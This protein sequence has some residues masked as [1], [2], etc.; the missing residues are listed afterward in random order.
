MRILGLT[1]IHGVLGSS[2][3]PGGGPPDRAALEP[4]VQSL[5]S[6]A[7]SVD[8]VLIAGDATHFGGR[9]EAAAAIDLL[10]TAGK[11]IFLVP[12]N[13]DTQGA[14]EYFDDLGV[15]LHGNIVRFGGFTLAGAGGAL[16]GPMSTPTVYS[17]EQFAALFDAL[18]ERIGPEEELI[19]VS[20]QPPRGTKLDRALGVRHVGS[21]AVRGWIERTN[22]L[23]CLCGHMHESSGIDRLGG[24]LLVNPGPFRHGNYCLI[25]IDEKKAVTATILP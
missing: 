24:T 23:L 11:P 21:E 12:G 5:L 14:I 6:A 7:E 25:E 3:S 18:S 2:A 4:T 16:P 20:H 19:L 10:R 17:E 9:K 13:C 1:D 15:N 22:P 8:C